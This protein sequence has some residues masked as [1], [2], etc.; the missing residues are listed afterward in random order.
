MIEDAIKK[1]GLIIL[2]AALGFSLIF[3]DGGVMGY[4]KARMDIG[5]VNAEIQKLEKENV[6]LIRELEKL[7]KDDK[8]LE[9]VVRTKYGF[10]RE[11]EKLYRVE[12]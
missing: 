7:Q 11:G 4:I 12:K 5:K 8:Y 2:M 3:A 10:V 1:Y 6:L 9:D